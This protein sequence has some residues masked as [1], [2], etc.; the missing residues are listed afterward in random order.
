[1]IPKDLF[2]LMRKVGVFPA[3]L[4]TADKDG[5]VHLTFVTWIY[6]IDEKTIRVALSSNAKSSKN[7]LQTGRACLMLM[8]QNT[9]L[10]CCGK[11]ALFQDRIEEVKFPVSVFEIRLES[12]EDALFPGGTITGTIPFMH[13]GD[14]QKA[15][16]L[17]QM[18]LEALR[19]L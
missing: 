3:V 10:A 6:P 12:V 9:S 17:D 13:T 14:L 16:E 15:G 5:N 2:E 18:V 1:M 7:L 19:S 4:A 11:A 8:A